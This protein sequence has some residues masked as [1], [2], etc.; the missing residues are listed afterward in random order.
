MV[1]GSPLMPGDDVKAHL[2]P[3]L[4]VT[5]SRTLPPDPGSDAALVPKCVTTGR[6][7]TAGAARA[8]RTGARHSAAATAAGAGRVVAGGSG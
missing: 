7:L 6:G 8:S 1:A 5:L 3:F 2:V 4:T